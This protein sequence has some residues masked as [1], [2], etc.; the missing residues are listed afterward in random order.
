MNKLKKII[1]NSFRYFGYNIKKLQ[2]KE[3][4]FLNFDEIYQK[5]LKNKKVTIFDVGANRGQS[6]NRFFENIS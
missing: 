1:L 3:K 5:I 2:K 4:N 6:I